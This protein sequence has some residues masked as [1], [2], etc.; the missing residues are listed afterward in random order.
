[1][2]VQPNKPKMGRPRKWPTPE[3]FD[4]W[5]ADYFKACAQA[6][7]PIP[8]TV[9]GLALHMGLSSRQELYDYGKYEG[10]EAV[11]ERCRMKIEQAY[12]FRL[13]GTTPT[14]AIFALTNM[15]WKNAKYI[16]HASTDG[17]MSPNKTVDKLTDEQLAAIVTADVQSPA[18]AT[19]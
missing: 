18:N 7:P 16:D 13:H 15:G 3:S 10:Y 14:G 8:L 4:E 19:K 11:V 1:M 5:A 9:T 12:E 6:S 17:S 2:T